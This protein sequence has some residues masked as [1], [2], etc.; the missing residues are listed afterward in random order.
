MIED[1]AL[2]ILAAIESAVHAGFSIEIRP[3]ASG[4]TTVSVDRVRVVT[5]TT[6]DELRPFS[7]AREATRDALGTALTILTMEL[8]SRRAAAERA[9][10]VNGLERPSHERDTRMV[11]SWRL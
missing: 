1:Q 8:Y 10:L 4:G 2:A 5:G 6:G 11:E 9:E 7:I 3:S